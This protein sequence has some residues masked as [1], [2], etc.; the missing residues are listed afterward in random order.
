MFWFTGLAISNSL[1]SIC[2]IKRI[3]VKIEI[4]KEKKE[5]IERKMKEKNNYSPKVRDSKLLDF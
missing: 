5:E 3:K 1:L 2:N 4:S